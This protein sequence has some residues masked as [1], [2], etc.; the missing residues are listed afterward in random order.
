MEVTNT[1]RGSG[2]VKV[3]TQNLTWYFKI[4][5]PEGHPEKGRKYEY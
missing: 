1:A 4:D 2:L 3:E 5:A